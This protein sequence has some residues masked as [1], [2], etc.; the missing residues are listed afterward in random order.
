MSNEIRD[1]L[2]AVRACVVERDAD[3]VENAIG[4]LEFYILDADGWPGDLFE[5]VSD[6]LGDPAFL[7]IPTSYRLARLLNE[8][9]DE[10]TSPQRN[11]VR[12]LLTSAFDRFGDWMG[13][14]V[15]AEIL[16]DRYADE[17]ALVAL[18]DLSSNGET[19]A[20]RE[21]AAYGLGRLT[22][23]VPEGPLHARA[24]DKLNALAVSSAPEV[25]KEALQALRRLAAGPTP[26]GG[27]PEPGDSN[28]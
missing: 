21:L 25:R 15:V 26:E 8:N 22:V 12:P 5:G 6:L 28:V 3:A 10:L 24:V 4:N 23:A 7:A 14:F 18:E 20:A 1:A 9:W 19:P 17:A 16:G 11:A 2:A 13:A 27:A